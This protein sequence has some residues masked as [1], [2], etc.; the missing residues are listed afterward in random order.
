[1]QFNP[2]HDIPMGLDHEGM[3]RAVPYPVGQTVRQAYFPELDSQSKSE[4]ESQQNSEKKSWYTPLS[5]VAEQEVNKYL[6]KS[7][8]RIF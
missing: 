1:M 7:K 2:I 3:P 6:G 8:K 5:D 4:V